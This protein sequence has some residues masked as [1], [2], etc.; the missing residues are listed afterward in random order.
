MPNKAPIDP[1]IIARMNNVDSGIRHHDFL[2]FN[3][4]IPKTVNVTAVI[5]MKYM[6]SILVAVMNIVSLSYMFWVQR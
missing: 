3:L 5:S 2:A 1:P 4:S 6:M